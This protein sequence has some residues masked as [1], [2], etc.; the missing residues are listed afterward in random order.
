MEPLEP[1]TS[2]DV[3]SRQRVL[4]RR[5]Q[6]FLIVVK[7]IL[8]M[9]L[10]GMMIYL[11]VGIAFG[12]S[13]IQALEF[14]IKPTRISQ[15]V[16]VKESNSVFVLMLMVIIC[17]I[18]L[19]GA[20]DESFTFSM[21]FTVSSAIIFVS[22]FFIGPLSEIFV[23]QIFILFLFLCSTMFSILIRKRRVTH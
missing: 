17:F 5:V 9:S 8:I 7:W 18:G 6:K 11:I 10:I 13:K 2:E 22:V 14:W 20:I 3:L 4:F 21:V 15:H 23:F 16:F 1:F 19:F 12:L